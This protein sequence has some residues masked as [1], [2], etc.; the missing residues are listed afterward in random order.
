MKPLLIYCFDAYAEWCYGFIPVIKK[1]ETRFSTRF[2]FEVLSGGLIR[3][4]K[5]T[6]IAAISDYM[7]RAY[8]QVEALSGMKFGEDF[9]WHIKN[10][11]E[12]DWFPDSLKPAMAMCI[13][14]EYL[15]EKQIDFANDL[16]FA[17]FSE[18]RDLCDDEAYRHLLEKYDL[19]AEKFYSRLHSD[20]VKQVANEDFHTISQL[21]ISGYPSLLLQL[22][23]EKIIHLA[24]SYISYPDI[25]EKILELI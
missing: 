22:Q 14:K 2:D 13:F 20:E 6:P 17:L 25:Q 5:P 23:P 3:A 9:L 24:A 7:M 8:P 21:G 19:P 16:S 12:S 15:F 4:A 1:L 18:G 11:K 10:S